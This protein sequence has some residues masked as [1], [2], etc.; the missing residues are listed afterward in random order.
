MSPSITID[1]QTSKTYL[2]ILL[3]NGAIIAT[4]SV[5][6]VVVSEILMPPCLDPMDG[7]ILYSGDTDYY[8]IEYATYMTIANS[9]PGDEDST[10]Y[11]SVAE[12]TTLT[13]VLEEDQTYSFSVYMTGDLPMS[14][15]FT[16][17]IPTAVG[18][19]S[20]GINGLTL[21]CTSY[22]DENDMT[23]TY[24]S[25]TRIITFSGP[26][27]DESS[28]IT[29]PGPIQFELD[30]FTNPSTSASAYFQWT[31]YAVLDNGTFMIDQIDSMYINAEQGEC[32][33]TYFY[34]TDDNYMIYGIADSWTVIMSCEHAFD[35]TYGIRL[36][37]PADW[38]V[39]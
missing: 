39:I 1:Q 38:Y 32:I 33:I 4:G 31:S 37:L 6:T 12:I 18:M 16:L 34:P 3:G 11:N 17:K 19:P 24:S 13:G 27:P 30:G 26:V 22:C 7:I 10:S 20:A 15:Y 14:G 35:S 9:L 2:K 23:M 28:Y 36:T 8:E 21:T 5:V 25:S 29:A